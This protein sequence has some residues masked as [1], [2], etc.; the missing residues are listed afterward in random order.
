MRCQLA[1]AGPRKTPLSLSLSLSLSFSLSLSLSLSFSLTHV[2]FLCS[3]SFP[4][5][6]FNP[7]FSVSVFFYHISP[8]SIWLYFFYAFFPSVTPALPPLLPFFS[9]SLVIS[10]SP[11]FSLFLPLRP[12]RLTRFSIFVSSIISFLCSSPFSASDSGSPY[13]REVHQTPEIF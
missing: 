7:P 6:H 8:L 9:I 12:L 10:L 11:Y 13:S 5:F 4:L 2:P 1:N 3:F